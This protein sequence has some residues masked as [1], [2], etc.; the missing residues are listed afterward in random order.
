MEASVAAGVQHFIY[1]SSHTVYGARP[2]NPALITEDY[3]SKPSVG[4]QYSMTKALSEQALWDFQR[5]HSQL[6]VTILRCCMVMGPGSGYVARTLNKPILLKV[7]GYDPELQFIHQDDLVDL[8][9]FLCDNPAEGVFNV[10]GEGAL[11]YSQ[12]IKILGKKAITLPSALAYPLVQ[13]TWRLGLQRGASRA[14]LD[15]VRYPIV[16]STDKLKSSLKFQ[17]HFTSE[18]ALRDYAESHKR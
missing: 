12:V 9:G 13:L 6:K 5:H 11:R 18:E 1:L 15:F 16:L 10:A 8:L 14:G 2:E 17:C 7:A 4:F 3:K